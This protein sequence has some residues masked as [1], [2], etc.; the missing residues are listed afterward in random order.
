MSL[1]ILQRDREGIILLD[2]KGRIT[3]GPETA[4]LWS[5]IERISGEQG[6]KV[7]LNFHEIDLIDSSGL[8]AMVMCQANLRRIGGVAKLAYL[9][10]HNLQ[11]LSPTKIYTIFEVFDDETEAVNS[12]FPGREIRRFDILAFVQQFKDDQASAPSKDE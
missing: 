11:L 10:W 8:G 5:V 6:P 7:I 1:E 12:F 4:V 9:N 2:L 3:A